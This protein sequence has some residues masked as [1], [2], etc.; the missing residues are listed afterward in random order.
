MSNVKNHVL[1]LL[2]VALAFFGFGCAGA[3]S[4]MK[5]IQAAANEEPS[6]EVSLDRIEDIDEGM[7]QV[8]VLLFQ[9]PVQTDSEWVGQLAG[10]DQG[11]AGQYTSL[12]R[13]SGAYSLPN[14]ALPKIKIF[15][16]HNAEILKTAQGQTAEHE[17]VFSALASIS[18]ESG[19][20][21]MSSYRDL[22][23]VKKEIADMETQKGLLEDAGGK[24]AEVAELEKAIEAKEASIEAKED[25]LFKNVEALGAVK[26]SPETLPLAKTLL[27]VFQHTA[28]MELESVTTAAIV[29]IQTPRAVPGIPGELSNLSQRWL[30]EMVAEVKGT[31]SGFDVS[32]IKPEI[33]LSNGVSV[34]L[35]GLDDE[36]LTGL[37]DRLTSKVTTFYDQVT[38]APGRALSISSQAE[39]HSK[40]LLSL[41]KALA[42]MAGE[43]FSENTGFEI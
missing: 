23:A 28:Q 33:D 34:K 18:G 9:V 12:A 8:E 4:S 37:P 30:S 17:S 24:E 10:L 27:K 2:L 40:F 25:E 6:I 22:N 35:T 13:Q 3:M 11:K 21:V 31:A 38:G 16:M 39:F 14:R 19:T 5:A 41:G 7:K 1:G 29:V 26:L 20:K 36:A 43:T 15:R 32:K 42:N